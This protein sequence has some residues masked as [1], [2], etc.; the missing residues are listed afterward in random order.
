MLTALSKEPEYRFASVSA[1]ANALE[2]ASKPDQRM[3]SSTSTAVSQPSS[4]S[5]HMVSSEEEA[6]PTLN[7]SVSERMSRPA[8]T[9]PQYLSLIHI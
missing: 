2:Q 4:R 3:Y 5:S 6:L 8:S 9:T 1:F 7:A